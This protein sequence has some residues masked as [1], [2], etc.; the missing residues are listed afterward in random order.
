M[1]RFFRPDYAFDTVYQ[2][3][4]EFIKAQGI[5]AL[6]VDLDNT[7]A[8]YDTPEPTPELLVWMERMERAGV[9]LAIVSNNCRERVERFCS[10][11]SIAYYW[12]SGKP[13]AKTIQK[14]LAALESS[15]DNTALVG[16]KL[17]TDVLGARR[18]G[19]RMIR[20]KSIKPRWKRRV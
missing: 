16:D 12:R 2:I 10:K 8:D 17:L 19:L 15:R 3:T 9:G 5:R 14:A 18:C 20:V 13:R 6:V 4:E 11:L 7:L 1:R